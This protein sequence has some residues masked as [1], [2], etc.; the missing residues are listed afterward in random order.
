MVVDSGHRRFAPLRW[1]PLRALGTISYGL[2]LYHVPVLHSV[3][4]FLPRSIPGFR[5]VEG[6]LTLSLTVAVAALS[7]RFI[8]QP[9]LKLKDRFDYCSPRRAS[10]AAATP[11][12]AISLAGE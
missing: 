2:Y 10:E 3:D 9:I 7:W 5:V 8:E 12:L 6:L 4:A 11:P 1:E